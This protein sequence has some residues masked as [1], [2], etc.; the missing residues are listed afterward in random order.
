MFVRTF[1]VLWTCLLGGGILAAEPIDFAKQVEPIF[2]AR[3]VKCHGE[4]KAQAKLR[5]NSASDIEA[6]LAAKPKLLV[7]GEPDESLLYQRLTL[8]ADNPKRMPKGGDPL[9][10]D[11][12]NLI[13]EWIRQGAVLMTANAAAPAATVDPKAEAKPIE[14]P[15]L[16]VVP[17]ASQSAVDKLTAAGARV[18]P[19]FAGSN[20]L[21][22][23]FAGRGE[24][25][26]DDDMV[27]LQ[28]VA[29][30]VY[31]LNLANA[32]TNAAGLS[33]LA[34][35]PHLAW[36]HLEH[37]TIDDAALAHLSQLSELEYL[38]LYG[39]PITDAGLQHLSKLPRLARLYLWQT[40][41]SY[42]AAMSL[43]QSIP[44][45]VVN[46]GFDHPVVARNRLTKERDDAQQQV[47]SA[48]ADVARM[49]LELERSKKSVETGTARL[50]EIEK[51]LKALAPADGL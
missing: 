5:L 42:D 37:A 44:G 50:G 39:T 20:L 14:K 22:V 31:T 49:E 45:L 43:E 24:P 21:D 4:A 16:P 1:V 41:A 38:N 2:A 36:L 33:P 25:A 34:Q 27:L 17:P 6:A 40:K 30:Q 51:E 48:K 28:G 47:E 32:H 15:A 19:L 26:G 11:Q 13:A 3:C 12:L 35:M 9:A 46:L 8:P 10:E 18:A 23:S 7:A 29:E